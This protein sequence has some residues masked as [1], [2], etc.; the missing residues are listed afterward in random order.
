MTNPAAIFE[1]WFVPALFAPNARQVVADTAIPPDA[2]VLDIACGS[3]IVAR[4][5]A[6]QDGPASRVVGL[7]ANPAML[8]EARRASEAEGLAITWVQ[9]DAQ[10][11]PFEHGSF[12]LVFCQHGLQFFPDRQGAVSEM[13]RVL[14]PG[15]QVVIVTWRGLDQNP[16]FAAFERAVRQRLG[17]PALEM[18]FALGDP[19]V[20]G[21]LLL[22]AGF[23]AVSVEPIEIEANYSDPARFVDFQIHA[24]A[25]AIPALQNLPAEDL[26][27]LIE[28]LR[29]DLAGPVQEATVGDRLRFPMQGIVARGI[30]P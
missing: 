4:T 26:D 19:A 1:S 15:G 10:R 7:D 28:A 2:R 18:P 14:A 22:E 27:V 20:L 21:S 17:S 12:D 9:G 16:F 8:A 24:S 11:L 6:R 13:Y 3:G 25:A 29:D 30:H 23:A 5:V